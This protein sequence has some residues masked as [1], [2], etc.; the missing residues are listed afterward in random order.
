ME[1]YITDAQF[2]PSSSFFISLGPL[3]LLESQGCKHCVFFL[4][5]YSIESMLVVV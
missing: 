2:D 4:F 5:S 1:I 3:Q